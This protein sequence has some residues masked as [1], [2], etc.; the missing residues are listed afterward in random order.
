MRL[1]EELTAELDALDVREPGW[2]A[3]VA[4]GR[5]TRRRRRGAI[6]AVVGA[7]LLIGPA[8]QVCGVLDPGSDRA[9]RVSAGT[10]PPGAP[11]DLVGQG[12][13]DGHSWAVRVHRRPDGT[14]CANGELDGRAA[15]FTCGSAPQVLVGDPRT[16][17]GHLNY[18]GG[19][20]GD[21]F[22]SIVG[23]ASDEVSVV[24]LRLDD[25]TEFRAVPTD[26]GTAHRYFAF[27][28]SG[29]PH[30]T[31]AAYDPLGRRLAQG[32]EK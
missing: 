12:T 1:R 10:A 28:F 26:V 22:G 5:R 25:G 4:A 9:V 17:I 20:F 15:G 8:V 24:V 19:P 13:I 6:G 30:Y 14:E 32:I 27:T 3:I 2:E 31:L 21:T 16:G 23:V 7:A 11:A 18:A 29:H